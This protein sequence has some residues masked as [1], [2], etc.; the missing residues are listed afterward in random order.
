MAFVSPQDPAWQ[1]NQAGGAA[2]KQRQ[3]Q[4]PAW[5]QRLCRRRCPIWNIGMGSII[6]LSLRRW[7]LGRQC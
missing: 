3:N 2:L 6:S 5:L 7:L 4:R 1:E